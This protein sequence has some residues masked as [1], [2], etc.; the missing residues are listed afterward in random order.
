MN[1]YERLD[2]L[3][4]GDSIFVDAHGVLVK[5]HEHDGK[6][7]LPLITALKEAQDKGVAVVLWTGGSFSETCYI[8]ELMKKHDLEFCDIF[9][10]VIKGSIIVDDRAVTPTWE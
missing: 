8:V 4:A 2:V 3:S 5:N 9:C 7:N 6:V 1:V 10:N